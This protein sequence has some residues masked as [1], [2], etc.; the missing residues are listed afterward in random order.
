M[1]FFF[2]S[3]KIAQHLECTGQLAQKDYPLSN[4]GPEVDGIA[5]VRFALG[6]PC[7]V[8]MIRSLLGHW[9][10]AS[11]NVNPPC[12]ALWEGGKPAFLDFWHLL[13][14]SSMSLKHI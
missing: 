6:V 1:A 14:S 2:A 5:K 3:L 12:T 4:A 8:Q 9:D 10:V 13:S 11:M 7:P